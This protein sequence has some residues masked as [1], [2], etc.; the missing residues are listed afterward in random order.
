MGQTVAWFIKKTTSVN[1]LLPHDLDHPNLQIVD[2]SL[3]AQPNPLW[4][5]SRILL[6]KLASEAPEKMAKRGC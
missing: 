2:F 5:P 3:L 4:L 6:L 1:E